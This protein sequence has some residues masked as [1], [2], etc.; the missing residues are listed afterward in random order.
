M[1]L[2][3][4]A[5]CRRRVAVVAGGARDNTGQGWTMSRTA[6]L[7][8]SVH[9]HW[10]KWCGCEGC[11]AARK[12][13][14]CHYKPRRRQRV[15]S[16]FH[17]AAEPKNTD[18][19]FCRGSTSIRFYG[20]SEQSILLAPLPALYAKQALRCV[21]GVRSGAVVTRLSPKHTQNK[22]PRHQPLRQTNTFSHNLFSNFRRTT[23]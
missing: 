14:S 9:W 23:F 8:P 10:H 17:R 20:R 2:N 11:T 21:K 1:A 4:S 16:Q 19:R 15:I 3:V 22:T 7:V 12:H 5:C 13:L 18:C 6:E